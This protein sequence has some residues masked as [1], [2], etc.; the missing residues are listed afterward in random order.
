MIERLEKF[1]NL[2]KAQ[3]GPY[4][5]ITKC[6]TKSSIFIFGLII[7]VIVSSIGQWTLQKIDHQSI[8]KDMEKTDKQF[9][10]EF[11]GELERNIR[12]VQF[13]IWAIKKNWTGNIFLNSSTIGQYVSFMQSQNTSLQD[14]YKID[15]KIQTKITKIYHEFD[16]SAEVIKKIN[17]VGY[18]SQGTANQDVDLL[19][20]IVN[21]GIE[22]YFSLQEDAS[23]FN[24]PY[25]SK[26]WSNQE[27][28]GKNCQEF[29]KAEERNVATGSQ[30][31]FAGSKK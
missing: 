8:S 21:K 13:Y 7:G 18:K 11:L 23:A 31:E 5:L 29:I 14:I 28:L 19:A 20:D 9:M 12:V 27:I 15:V 1:L 16:R 30:V 3:L 4:P 6:V 24:K 25:L 26:G 17:S 2:H 22:V 10:K